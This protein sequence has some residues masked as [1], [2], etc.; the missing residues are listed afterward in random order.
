[1]SPISPTAVDDTTPKEFK[2]TVA[3]QHTK[4]QPP[5]GVRMYHPHAHAY[6]YEVYPLMACTGLL[7]R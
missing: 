3:G 1:M 2:D 7:S 4:P 6:E 5:A